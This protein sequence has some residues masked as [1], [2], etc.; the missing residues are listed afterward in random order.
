MERTKGPWEVSSSTIVR[1]TEGGTVICNCLQFSTLPELP[2]S[3]EEAMTNAH[4]IAAAP[5]L[6]NAAKHLLINARD[7][8]ECFDDDG[9]MYDD[10]KLLEEAVDKAERREL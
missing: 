6:L 2:P 5:N 3:M 8:D 1:E 10:W 4:L 9:E 7:M